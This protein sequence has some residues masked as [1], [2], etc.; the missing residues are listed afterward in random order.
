M[1]VGIVGFGNMG[2]AFANCLIRKVGRENITVTDV[3]PEKRSLAVEMGLAFATDI[4]FLADTSELVIIAVK[5]KDSL[6][7]LEKL[8]EYKGIILSIMAGVS[9]EDIE[10]VVGKDKKI[11]RV[12]PNIAVAVGSGTMAITDNGKLS[13]EERNR[14]EE[15]LLSCGSLYRIEE[16]LFDAFTALAGSSPAYV[17][18]FIDGLALG[19]VLLGF[20]YEQSLK[21][22]LDTVRGCANLLRET[23][24]NPNALTTR[25]TSPAGTT[26]EGLKH[27]E[28]KGFKGILMECLEKT[29]QKAKKLK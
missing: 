3:L 22:V 10:N 27:L 20:S 28:S 23:G 26:I 19:G 5:P 8:K 16:G 6:K 1:R 4:K 21:I 15:L 24:E 17:F 2:Q 9:L 7:V 18:Q 13:D 11:V 29:S 14:V 25:V 12:M